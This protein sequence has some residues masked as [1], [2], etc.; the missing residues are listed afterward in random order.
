MSDES[1]FLVCLTMLCDWLTKFALLSQPMR[2]K[3]K[4]N[5]AA[6]AFSRAWCRFCVFASNCDWSFV[7]FEGFGGK[8]ALGFSL[9]SELCQ[10]RSKFR[11]QF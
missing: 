1:D 5:H 3:S 4:T 9:K 11:T 6:R 10:K 2:S 8:R 7:L